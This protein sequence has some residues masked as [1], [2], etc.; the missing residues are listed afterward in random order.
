MPGHLRKRLAQALDTGQ[1]AVPYSSSILQMILGYSDRELLAALEG[2]ASLGIAGRGAAHWIR[3]L[4]QTIGATPSPDLVWSGP[5]VPG[6]A[7]RDTRAVYDELFTSFTRSLWAVS[8]AYFD[9]PRVFDAAG[10]DAQALGRRAR[11]SRDGAGDHRASCRNRP[12]RASKGR[13][14]PAEDEG[15][16]GGTATGTHEV[17]HLL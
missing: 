5:E 14:I 1:M 16:S 12:R 9:G 17:S 7:A 10:M 11:A 15:K 6:V 13:W 8:Y 2:L 4:D 3:A